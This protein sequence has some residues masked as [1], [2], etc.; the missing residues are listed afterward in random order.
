MMQIIL[1]ILVC[2]LLYMV[3]KYL[4]ADKKI[5]NKKEICKDGKKHK[6]SRWTNDKKQKRHCTKC[7]VKDTL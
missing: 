3:A 1:F 2:L 5:N 6:W 4:M 7:D